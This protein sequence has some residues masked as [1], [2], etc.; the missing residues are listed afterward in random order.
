MI[1]QI[2]LIALTLISLY[3]ILTQLGCEECNP[4]E[5]RCLDNV[6]QI[7][8]SDGM[9]QNELDCVE[10]DS[11]WQCCWDAEYETHTC[12]PNEECNE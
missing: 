6:V 7:C 11:N 9:W 10:V 1:E 5:T 12:V 2:K 8:N 3:L 4:E